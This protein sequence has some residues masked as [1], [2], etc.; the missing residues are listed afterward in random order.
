[1]KLIDRC[2]AIFILVFS[3]YAGYPQDYAFS[4]LPYPEE[5]DWGIISGIAQ[6]PQGNMWFAGE[7]LYRYDG[8]DFTTYPSSEIHALCAA[9]DGMIW[10]GTAAGLERLDPV[11]GT[12]K[13]F[14]AHL[15]DPTELPADYI[16]TIYQDKA[17]T[18]WVGTGEG[19]S[20]YNAQ[21][22]NFTSFRHNPNDPASISDNT[23]IALYEDSHG[24][25]WIGTGTSFIQQRTGGLNKLDRAT[26]K[27]T[28]YLHNDNDPASLL[29]DRIS[30]ILEDSHG[31]F[32]VGSANNG[33]HIMDRAKG[34]F[35][36]LLYDSLRPGA[37]SGPQYVKN[38]EPKDFITFISEDAAGN[39]W[40]GA[41]QGGLV[42]YNPATKAVV[43]YNEN[44]TVNTTL[45]SDRMFWRCYNSSDGIVWM[46]TWEGSLFKVDP[47][48]T[49]LPF[50]TLSTAVNEA[51]EDSPGV[52]WLAT[53]KTGL[54]LKDLEK[55]TE[56]IFLHDEHNP[57]SISS[58]K[59]LSLLKGSDGMLW[60]GTD[61]GLNRFNTAKNEFTHYRRE[62]GNPN[63]L[64]SDTVTI[65]REDKDRLLWLGAFGGG[66]SSFNRQTGKF[67][68]YKHNERDTASISSDAV[69][70]ILEDNKKRLW[71]GNWFGG[72]VNRMDGRN[73]KFTHYLPGSNV[74]QLY[75]D[76]G[77]TIWACATTG[78]Y[79]FSEKENKFVQFV[80]P[81]TGKNFIDAWAITEDLKKNLW[82]RTRS[83]IVRINESRSEVKLLGRSYGV[84]P[85]SNSFGIAITGRRGN[86]LFG[87]TGGYFSFFPEQVSDKVSNPL[88]LLTEL[89]MKDKKVIPGESG[90]LPKNLSETGK[91]N[92]A[93]NQNIFSITF[94]VINYSDEE[95]GNVQMMLE[96]YDENWRT[97]P[98]DGVCQFYSVPPGEYKFRVKLN[99][100]QDK[101]VEKSISI[102]I[103]PPWWKTWWAYTL[104]VIIF[105]AG[106]WAFIRYRSAALR[107]KNIVLEEKVSQRT[108]ELKKSL[109]EL[110][111]TQ[112]QLI[113][114]EKM[115]SLGQLTAG[116][117][118]EIQNPLNFVNNFSEVNGE[119]ISELKGELAS[120]SYRNG[121][122]QNV[123]DIIDDIN[124]NLTKINQ[125][126]K[127]ADA[128]VKGMLEH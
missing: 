97:A 79:R 116:I 108:T 41:L 18:I 85:L 17:G 51:V 77:G 12:I 93:Y 110:R 27:F 49:R 11:T 106:L 35:Q 29:D 126:G 48:R 23:V 119:L 33:L 102:I 75:L 105:I 98:A 62:D 15:N 83:A 57:N 45:F 81:L 74:A 21:K 44:R 58:N 111:A 94:K 22:E 43:R 99:V 100:A 82:V 70:T 13:K 1:M 88:L 66:L 101:A 24:E 61:K 37:L 4:R 125:H 46:N 73:G 86:I 123:M 128:I 54:V 91:I 14:G 113:Q 107:R 25:F 109:E 92:F 104:Y 114:S 3:T 31:V 67:T 20:R 10:V 122:S 63:S 64:P 30:A 103:H 84:E 76:A 55:N 95:A 16:N 47:S 68:P 72:G 36:R 52:F 78:L 26:G 53:Q 6:D 59:T 56:K 9:K 80:N 28:R 121:N 127:R 96:N 60:V 71:T 124:Q 89:Q 118:H 34:T 69:A 39:I 120:D 38:I 90:I 7:R 115:A 112:A 40:I 32:W 2:V 65:I 117:A 87:Q 5:G 42:S 19:L 50:Y 8:K